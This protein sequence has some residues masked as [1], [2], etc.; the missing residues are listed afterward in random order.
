MSQS[1]LF[2]LGLLGILPG[3]QV[4]SINTTSYM[5]RVAG[6][7]EED[8]PWTGLKYLTHLPAVL[9]LISTHSDLIRNS[10]EL[11]L[12]RTEFPIASS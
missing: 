2:G 5:V 8:G 11:L 4:I 10:M 12:N 7:V 1:S 3:A 6:Q 9:V